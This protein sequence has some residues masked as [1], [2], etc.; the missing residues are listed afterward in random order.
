MLHPV[1]SPFH[2]PMARTVIPTPHLP[3]FPAVSQVSSLP[4][5][6]TEEFQPLGMLLLLLLPWPPLLPSLQIPLLPLVHIQRP[7]LLILGRPG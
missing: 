4:R 1:R 7:P 3:V 6:G 2:R 5:R